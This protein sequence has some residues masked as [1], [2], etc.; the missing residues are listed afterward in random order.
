MSLIAIIYVYFGNYY[1]KIRV[2]MKQYRNIYVASQNNI[3]AFSLGI[4][5]S[6][7]SRA[8]ERIAGFTIYRKFT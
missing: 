2:N 7:K 8:N 3:F 5:F 1:S 4:K 6:H